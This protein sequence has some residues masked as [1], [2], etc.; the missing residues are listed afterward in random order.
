MCTGKTVTHVLRMNKKLQI[1]HKLHS[2]VCCFSSVLQSKKKK[3][4]KKTYRCMSSVFHHEESQHWQHRPKLRTQ[5]QRKT[6][7]PRLSLSQFL[8]AGH[9]HLTEILSLHLNSESEGRC[10]N[11][12]W[13]R[14]AASQQP[15]RE[16]PSPTIWLSTVSQ[17]HQ[18]DTKNKS[19]ILSSEFHIRLWNNLN[20]D[21]EIKT[22]TFRLLALCAGSKSWLRI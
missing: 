12:W 15:H 5:T 19:Y 3:K 10:W 1:R 6:P 14:P 13:K 21:A 4:K 8:H 22:K 9:W 17:S 2:K 20:N 16:Q 7:S 18:V 11:L